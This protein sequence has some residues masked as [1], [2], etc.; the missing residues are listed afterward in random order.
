[1]DDLKDIQSESSYRA[2][3]SD[4]D[5]AGLPTLD[6]DEHRLDKTSAGGNLWD[7]LEKDISKD[8]SKDLDASEFI[9][10]ADYSADGEASS[11][12][13]SY[14]EAVLENPEESEDVNDFEMPDG[15]GDLPPSE[16]FMVGPTAEEDRYDGPSADVGYQSA[17]ELESPPI[18][19][20]DDES[21]RP[22]FSSSSSAGEDKTVSIQQ[23][24]GATSSVVGTDADKTVAV[25]GFANAR[26]GA[27][28]APEVDV[29]VSVG[30]FRGSR[31]SANVMTSVDASLAQAEN[32]K[33]AQQ[34]ILELEKEVEFLRAEN[35][36]LASAGEIIRSRTDDLT[37]RISEIEKEKTEMQESAQSEI[38]IL[39][40]NLQYKE[41][42]VAKARIKVEELEARLKSDFKK[43]RVRER[44]LENRLELLR[45]EKS[46]LVRSKD[47]YIL[48]QKRKIDQLSQELDNYRKKC[49]ELNKTIEANQ[50]QVKRTERALR[51]A[52]TNLE[53][54]EENLVP[55]KKA[56]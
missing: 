7:N 39:K 42:E 36:E 19:E 23:D 48:E 17:D 32:L 13:G 33:L 24:F 46:A 11:Y 10:G 3:G 28:K 29:K 2:G 16:R 43:I 18:P 6:A 5:F 41:N 52:L 47:E 4:D 55:L 9:G 50:D 34:R 53:A 56:E 26:V 15:F 8:P 31:G 14:K 51:L 22:V 27:R 45:A 37:V 44:E 30:N 49:L 38:L 25:E 21:T 40:G 12:E 54:K 1:M 35:E 20:M